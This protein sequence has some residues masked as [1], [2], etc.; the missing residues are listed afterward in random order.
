[1][2]EPLSVGQWQGFFSYG[3]EYGEI[4]E[5]AEVEFRMFIEHFKNGEFSGRIIDW[6]GAGENGAVCFM[7]GFI[8]GDFIS[9]IKQYNR[10]HTFDQWGNVETNDTKGYEVLYEGRLFTKEKCVRGTWEISFTIADEAEQSIEEVSTGTW[11]ILL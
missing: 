3:P 2:E 9:F 1:M 8:D 11:R 4:L 5:G 10:L 6:N 7:K